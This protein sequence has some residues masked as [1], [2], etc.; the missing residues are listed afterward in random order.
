MGWES[1]G[2]GLYYYKKRRE[3][4][5]VKSE[6][7]GA[8]ELARSVAAI[9]EIDQERRAL[10]RLERQAERSKLEQFDQA[11]KELAEIAVTLTRACLLASGYHTHKG[12]WRRKRAAATN[13]TN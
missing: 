7:Y 6:Y 13:A 2:N 3:G 10:G 8:G 12:T 5:R 4:G 9:E 1:R 11:N